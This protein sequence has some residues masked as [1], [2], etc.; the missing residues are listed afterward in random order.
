MRRSVSIAPKASRAGCV[1]WHVWELGFTLIV[2]MKDA[3]IL[4]S[5]FPLGS[6]SLA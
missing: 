3:V 6:P 2:V 5:S 1:I 4:V